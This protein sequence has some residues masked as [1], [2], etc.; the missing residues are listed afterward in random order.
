AD[1]FVV[2]VGTGRFCSCLGCFG[3]KKPALRRV[4]IWFL[5]GAWLR[6][7]GIVTLDRFFLLP[8]LGVMSALRCVR[9]EL[10]SVHRY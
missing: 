9:I 8:T 3:Q 7:R 10:A 2:M 4:L 1:Q 6:C 5:A